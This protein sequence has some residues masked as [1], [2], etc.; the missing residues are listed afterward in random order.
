ALTSGTHPLHCSA[1]EAMQLVEVLR[2]GE[3]WPRLQPSRSETG[4]RTYM[5]RMNTNAGAWMVMYRPQFPGVCFFCAHG[6]DP[7]KE[8]PPH[9]IALTSAQR[10]QFS[11]AIF[12]ALM[13]NAPAPARA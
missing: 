12:Q 8:P 10:Q 4:S 9:R 2:A 5:E 7:A 6:T 11:D 1:A 3:A 13:Q